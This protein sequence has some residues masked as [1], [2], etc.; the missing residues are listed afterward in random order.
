M[1]KDSNYWKLVEA[2]AKELGSDGCSGVSEWNQECCYEHD[3]AY[4][5]GAN[6]YGVKQTRKETDDAFYECN[7]KRRVSTPRAF[8]RWL[9]VR[10]FGGGAWKGDKDAKS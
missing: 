1:T 7:K 8:I 2:K 10:I 5:T 3:I 4:K 9:G 6:V